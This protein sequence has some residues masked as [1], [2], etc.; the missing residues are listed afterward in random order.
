MSATNLPN[1]ERAISILQSVHMAFLGER[2]KYS[3]VAAIVVASKTQP[4]N[5]HTTE[6]DEDAKSI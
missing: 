6:A 2:A 3:I 4:F 1:C 5:D